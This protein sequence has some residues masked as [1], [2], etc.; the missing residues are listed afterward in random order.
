MKKESMNLKN[1]NH[2]QGKKEMIYYTIISKVKETIKGDDSSHF[3]AGLLACPL[4]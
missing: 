4:T 3:T 1:K 2:F